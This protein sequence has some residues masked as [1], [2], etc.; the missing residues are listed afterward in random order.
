[1]VKYVA[2]KIEKAS[3]SWRKYKLYSGHT[4]KLFFGKNKKN[5][6]NQ[7]KFFGFLW[8]NILEKLAENY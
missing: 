2:L 3:Y 1:M 4:V 8:K 6:K 5:Q 7:R